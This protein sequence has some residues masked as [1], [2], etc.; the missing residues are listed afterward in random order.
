MNPLELESQASAFQAAT[1]ILAANRAGILAS[2]S[3]DGGATAEQLARRLGLDARAVSTLCDALLCLGVVVRDGDALAVAAPL[4]DLLD[5]DSPVAVTHILEHQWHLLQRWSH[6][7]E[8]VRTGSPLPRGTGNERA[9][10]AF[11]LGMADLA[12]RGSRRLWESVDLS[13]YRALVDV[14]GGP[15]EFAVAALERFPALSATVFDSPPVLAIAREYAAPRG[16]GERLAFRPGDAL[17]EAIPTSDVAL[18]FSLLHSYGSTEVE[19]IAANVA[20]GLEPG[21]LLIIREF[22][23]ASSHHEGPLSTA[24]FAVNMLVGTSTGRCW[25]AEEIEAI[26]TPHGF[27]GWR[28]VAIDPRSTFLLADRV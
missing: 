24:L 20:A 2:L 25:S 13:R 23:W 5:P 10:R 8:V 22:L 6:L 18:V 9:R 4:R 3:R 28:Q 19:R 17:A 16:V 27:A 1:V 15:G 12:R 21:G 26:F 14:G 11:I 7:D